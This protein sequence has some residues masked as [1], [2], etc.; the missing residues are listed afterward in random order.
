MM[1]RIIALFIF[2]PS[3][4]MA[5]L[6]NDQDISKVGTTAAQ[7]LKISSGSRGLAMGSANIAICSDL[8]SSFWNPAGLSHLKGIQVYFENNGWLAGTDYNYGS[9]GFNWP[10]VGVFSLSL[11]MLSSPDDLVRTVEQPNGTGEQFN[12]Q[13]MSIGISVGKSLTDQLS[14]GASIKNV[15]Q[16]IWHSSGRRKLCWRTTCRDDWSGCHRMFRWS[17]GYKRGLS[18]RQVSY[19][20]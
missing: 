16:R 12:S 19:T 10:S 7:F 14:L 17:A 13:D 11:T 3:F 15:R 9:F 8:T 20:L 5:Q 2:I 18:W 6:E 4:S 1:K